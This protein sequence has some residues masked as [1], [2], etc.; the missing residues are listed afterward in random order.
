MFRLD[1]FLTLHFLGHLTAM[2]HGPA[3]RIPIL[4]YH[5]IS[6]D[7]EPGVHPYYR[8]VTT[9]EVFVEHMNLLAELGCQALDIETAAD[10]L[11]SNTAAAKQSAAK[12]VAITFDDGFRDFYENAFPILSRFHFAATVFLPAAF[13]GTSVNPEMGRRF[14]SWSQANELANAGIS[15]GS[16]SQSHNY[17]VRMDRKAVEMELWKSKEIIED[18]IGRRV[19]AFSHPNA[20]PEHN[21]PYV[22]FLREALEKYGYS[23]AVTTMIGTAE[24]K[25]DTFF[26][27]R[28]PVNSEDDISFFKA[29]INGRYDWMHLAQYGAKK[30]KGMLKIYGKKNL[31]KWVSK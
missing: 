27:R 24:A 21:K 16:H 7:T 9:P 2:A 10:L 6:H 19:K 23:S 3:M 30:A 12:Y 29:K 4:M 5:S 8:M 31:V 17:L 15:I 1:R 20:F 11:R 25:A 13:I 14:I 22:S 18:N 28:I 26:L